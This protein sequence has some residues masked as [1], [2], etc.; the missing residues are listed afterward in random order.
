VFLDVGIDG[1]FDNAASGEYG[2]ILTL[3]EWIEAILR[4][5]NV[6]VEI[7]GSSFR[8]LVNRRCPQGRVLSPLL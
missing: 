5:R 4:F 6:R 3:R 7:R 1:A 8:V 2:V